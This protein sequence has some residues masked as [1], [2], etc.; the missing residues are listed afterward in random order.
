MTP[1]SAGKFYITTPIYYPNAEP[2]VGSA[3]EVIGIDVMA[4][5]KRLLGCDVYLLTGTDEH[6]EKV[7]KVAEERGVSPEQLVEEMAEKFK[8]IWRDLEV[9]FDRFIRTEEPA[10]KEAVAKFWRRVRE[11]G[12]IYLG[13]YEGLYC[14]PC[15]SYWTATQAKALVCPECGRPLETLRE[16][17][18]FFALSKYQKPLEKLFSEN[19]DF[20][21]P[22]FRRR[23]MEESFLKPGLEDICISRTTIRWGIPVPDDPAHVV[24]VWFDALINYLTGAGYGTDEKTFAKWWPADLHVVGKDI[25]RFHTLL[26]PAMLMAADLPLPKR[27]FGHGFVQV[28]SDD[29]SE[30]VKMSKSLGNIVKPGDII[31]KYGADALRYFLMREIPY[32]SDGGYSERNLAVRYNTDLAND[33]GN[34][35]LRSIS[36][37]ERY[38]D[39]RVPEG[40]RRDVVNW[41]DGD[42]VLHAVAAELTETVGPMMEALDYAHA[43]EGIWEMVRAANRYV[44]E[45]RPWAL[46]KD[47]A[48]RERLGVVLY[49]LAEACRLL[50]VWLSPFIPATCARIRSQLALQDDALS[51]DERVSW[52]RTKAG[53]TLRKDKPLFPRLDL[54]GEKAGPAKK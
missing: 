40:D 7:S 24:Y 50:S 34:L 33:L 9:S 39:S 31:A 51:F 49:N 11:R 46:A 15:E 53:T 47:P 12:D 35:V 44:E 52:G 26:W 27:V 21:L 37:I 28:M 14:M 54:P 18:Y 10:H 41:P 36:M 17:A 25:V 6:A 8:A 29:S 16:P 38:F 20:L 19:P 23:E 2:H 3:F 48:R 4:R 13:S 30:S 22:D 5:W 32:S 1:V 45:S 42:K 43:I